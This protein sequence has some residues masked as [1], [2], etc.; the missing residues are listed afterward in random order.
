MTRAK[1]C[2]ITRLEDA[3]WAEALGAWALGFVLVPSSRRYL[4]PE[5]VRPIARAVGPLVVRVGVFA[6][7][8][9]EAVLRQMEAA[10]LQ[11]VQLHGD[12]PPEWAEQVGR[13]FPVIKAIRLFG[14]ASAGW[15]SYP[16]EALLV[17]GASPG[18]GRA[19]PLE[20]LEPLRPHPRLIIAGGLTVENLLAVLALKPYGV[21]VSSGVEAA[22]GRKDPEK[23]RGFLGQVARFNGASQ[24]Q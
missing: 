24:N 15:L 6:N 9:P 17:D 1:I 13:F 16:A 3:L 22:P 2:G 14:P 7:T 11:V 10:G 4:S 20:W 8:P 19:Y 12:E 23:L 18:S 5:A 21:D